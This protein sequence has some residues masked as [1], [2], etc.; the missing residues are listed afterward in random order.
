MAGAVSFGAGA[1]EVEGLVEF[2]RSLAIL[3]R[4]LNRELRAGLLEAA[5]PVAETAHGLALEKIP[6]MRFG[7]GPSWAGMRVGASQGLVYV[8]PRQHGTR[9]RSR[10][11]PNLAGL[12][13]VRAMEPAS[14]QERDRVEA[15]VETILSAAFLKAGV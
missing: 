12:L 4:D 6:R 11:R 8:A 9:Q 2:Q 3:D 10:K 7:R 13:I 1:V 14:E 5:Q 15:V